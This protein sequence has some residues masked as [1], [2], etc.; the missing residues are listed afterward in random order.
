MA[1]K[2]YR[3]TIASEI[4][5]RAGVQRLMNVANEMNHESQSVSASLRRCATVAENTELI[6]KRARDAAGCGH[7]IFRDIAFPRA[8]RNVDEVPG[9][10]I[11]PDFALVV[12]PRR[13]IREWIEACLLAIAG[14]MRI[15]G[16]CGE[17]LER[18]R[19]SARIHVVLGDQ[20][21]NL[22]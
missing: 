9:R 16:A 6:G 11:R 18:H 22:M 20:C 4:V 14:E 7:A 12:C 2:G 8:A 5:V 21:Y 17:N 10:G 15:D 1:E 13:G 3:N 19:A